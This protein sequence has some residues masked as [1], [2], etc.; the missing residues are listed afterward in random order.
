MSTE[1]VSISASA[2][3]PGRASAPLSGEF[4]L[5]RAR[6][7]AKSFALG[8]LLAV[9]F[10]VVPFLGDDYW[11]SAILI[12]LL[13]LSLVGLGLN[14]LT[15]YAGQ[16]SLGSAAFMAAGAFATYNFE[17]RVPGLPLLVSV[18][19]GGLVAALIGVAF[20]LPSLRIKGFYLIVSTLAAQF[21][22]QWALTKFGWFSND[23]PSGVIS[24]AHNPWPRSLESR[25]ALPAHAIHRHLPHLGGLEL[26]AEPHRSQLDGY[27]RHGHSRSCH[28]YPYLSQ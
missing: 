6:P 7:Q 25:W 21:F 19:L 1:S 23:N 22:I 26:G 9:A 14:L 15:G 10:L 18:V 3:Q 4:R 27:P 5:R 13:V 20:G 11:F 8:V 28:R 24:A 2:P 16:L 12:P 17:P